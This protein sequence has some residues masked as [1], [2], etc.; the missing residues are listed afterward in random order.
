MSLLHVVRVFTDVTGSH[1]NPLGVFVDGGRTPEDRRQSIAAELGFSETVFA[2]DR[3]QGRIRLY[4][5]ASELPFAGH[6]LVGAA[7]LLGQQRGPVEHL[8]PPAGEVPVW[9]EGELVWVRGRPQWCPPWKHQR[10][11]SVSDVEQAT[12]AP[13]GHDAVQVWAMEDS[14]AGIVRARVFAPRFGVREDEACGSASMLL[15]VAL[16]RPLTIRHGV[17]SE[18]YV[19]PGPDGAVDLGGRVK[20]VGIREYP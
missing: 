15:A 13:A 11:N 19:R 6:A 5:P 8:W 2:E 16:A 7:W 17:G 10:A 20:L 18:I 12:E 14:A 1:G 9:T 4:T 3:E